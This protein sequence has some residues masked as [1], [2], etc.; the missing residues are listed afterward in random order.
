M[1]ENCSSNQR[2]GNGENS[3]W[4]HLDHHHNHFHFCYQSSWSSPL[5][6]Q[7]S[8]S[9]SSLSQLISSAWWWP[10]L[11]SCKMSKYEIRT[12]GIRRHDDVIKWKHFPRY[13]PF[14]RGIHRWPVNS[15][16][17][18]QW[19]GALMLSLISAS[20]NGWVN[21]RDVAIWDAIAPIM[22]PL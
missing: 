1:R 9:L 4:Y 11:L 7:L 2:P 15:P 10:S 16:H 19:R 17:K 12:R 14:V 20:I 21:Y 8:L 13:W 3:L 18:G 6:S 5:S 22:T